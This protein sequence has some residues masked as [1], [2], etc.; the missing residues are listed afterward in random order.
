MY[1]PHTGGC[2]VSVTCH[3]LL[4]IASA[5]G[6]YPEQK[7]SFTGKVQQR[8][9]LKYLAAARNVVCVSANTARELAVFSNRPLQNVSVIPNPLNFHGCPHWRMTFVCSP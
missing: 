5:Q 2:P 1:L 7:V 4:A 9:I 6:R 3:D 8:W